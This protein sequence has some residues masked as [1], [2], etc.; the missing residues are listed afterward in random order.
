MHANNKPSSAY[1]KVNESTKLKHK[2]TNGGAITTTNGNSSM[3]DGKSNIIPNHHHATSS[4]NHRNKRVV[5]GK[6]SR[7]A[8]HHHHHQS[9]HSLLG[10]LK[11]PSLF[12]SRRLAR[13]IL[14]VLK[15]AAALNLFRA[16]PFFVLEI[17][18]L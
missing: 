14:R 16:I 18:Y 1:N 13:W 3:S 8:A 7:H 6:G 12:P 5:R 15:V 10:M 2:R 11:S 17:Y 4:S 9:R